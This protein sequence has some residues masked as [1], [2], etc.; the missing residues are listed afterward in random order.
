MT[1]Y[2]SL[3]LLAGFTFAALT[4]VAQQPAPKV[5]SVPTPKVQSV[6]IKWTPTESAPQMYTTYCAACHG[7]DAK[8]NGPAAPAMKIPPTDL[9]QLAKRNGGVF[10]ANRVGSILK[11]GNE[12]LAHGSKD[13]PIWGDLFRTIGGPSSDREA[14]IRLRISNLTD[15]L[16]QLQK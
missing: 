2:R 15:Y 8:G 11:M 9:T 1:K 10:P 6:P 13:M 3:S 14:Q 7:A 12:D 5:H 16:Q 4:A